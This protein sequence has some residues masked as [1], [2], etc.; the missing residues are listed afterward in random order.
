MCIMKR[1]SLTEHETQ[2]A[3]NLREIWDSK[4]KQLGL[5]Q[6]SA[7]EL[8]RM[9][10]GGVGQYLNGIIPLNI[11]AKLKFAKLLGVH[12]SEI[13]PQMTFNPLD[14]REVDDHERTLR[15]TVEPAGLG[16]D[17]TPLGERSAPR[18]IDI[19][20]FDVELAAGNGTHIDLE[21]VTE[22]FP[23]SENRLNDA[24]V[25]PSQAAI[26]KVR[27]DSMES[28]L[29]SGDVVLVDTS[30]KRPVSGKIFAFAFDDDLR[31]KRFS[32]RLDGSWRI[33]S[34]NGDNP[35]YSDET[36]SAH[37]ITQQIRIIG[38]VKVL[39]ERKLG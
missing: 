22:Y 25:V 26:V 3:K 5:T 20:V 19:P 39:L 38:Q 29:Y 34:D 27:G 4:K 28:T 8:L 10:Q 23:V 11:D 32:K 35:A 33:S 16:F 1:R 17:T 6:E 37:D 2:C 24:H 31:V 14:A 9:T 18:F 21:R 36:L 13:D 30:V 15:E 12:I 7:G